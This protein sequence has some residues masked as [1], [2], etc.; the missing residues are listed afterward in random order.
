MKA[1]NKSGSEYCV[2]LITEDDDTL[3]L[4]T[5]SIEAKSGMKPDDCTPCSI[6]TSR[7]TTE[8]GLT[9][10]NYYFETS[11]LVSCFLKSI[12]FGTNI[13]KLYLISPLGVHFMEQNKSYYAK[14][15]EM[16]NILDTKGLGYILFQGKT[17]WFLSIP[18]RSAENVLA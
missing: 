11:D 8:G 9:A 4:I 1:F 12:H 13:T 6:R 16:S 17:K 10:L 14:L 15:I 5:K 18:G 7:G 2:I 3:E